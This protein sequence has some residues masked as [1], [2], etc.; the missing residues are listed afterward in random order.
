MVPSIR[1][2]NVYGRR[3]SP[4]TRPATQVARKAHSV[5][6]AQLDSGR[7]PVPAAYPGAMRR[8]PQRLRWLTPATL[9]VSLFCRPSVAAADD[10]RVAFFESRIR[11]VLIRSC[12]KCHSQ[13]SDPLESDLR[14]DVGLTKAAALISPGSSKPYD[15]RTPSCR[16]RPAAAWLRR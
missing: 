1:W 10:A 16:C 3:E 7:H 12:Y 8:R 9:L 13:H 6:Q 15:I 11:P 4:V 2:H 14:L 5:N